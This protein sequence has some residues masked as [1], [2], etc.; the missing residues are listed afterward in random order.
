M[1]GPAYNQFIHLMNRYPWGLQFAR[2]IFHVRSRHSVPF[3]SPSR[4][5]PRTERAFG[6]FCNP[7]LLKIPARNW[8]GDDRNSVRSI[9]ALSTRL[10]D[11]LRE[12][13]L[14][15]AAAKADATS[16]RDEKAMFVL[17]LFARKNASS[18]PTTQPV[19]IRAGLGRQSAANPCAASCASVRQS[20]IRPAQARV[21][22]AVGLVESPGVGH[23]GPSALSWHPW[24]RLID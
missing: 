24:P 1:I 11:E 22:R 9:V 18:S 14:P 20:D 4:G 16:E 12:H 3:F 23:P 13:G 19:V 2:W 8:I 21:Q 6:G 10:I 17:L 15:P 5:A 7:I